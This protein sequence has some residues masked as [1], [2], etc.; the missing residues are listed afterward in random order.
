MNGR[1]DFSQALVLIKQGKRLTRTGWNGKGMTVEIQ[2]PDE[3]SKMTLPYLFIRT[4]DKK[5]VPWVASV[6]DL[7]AEDWEV[8]E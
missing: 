6:T 1:M 4:T 2:R 5:N 3:H 8:V 7:L